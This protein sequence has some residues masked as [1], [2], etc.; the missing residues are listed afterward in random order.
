MCSNS[1]LFRDIV[2][3]Y[4]D[5]SAFLMLVIFLAVLTLEDKNTSSYAL[6]YRVSAFKPDQNFII[7]Q[8][9]LWHTA[10]FL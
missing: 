1:F 3:P 2:T 7:S 9:Y 6:V 4:R 5:P 8:P 10:L